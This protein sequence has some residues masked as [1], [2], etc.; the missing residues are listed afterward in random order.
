MQ[1][2]KLG[3]MVAALCGFLFLAA[4][5]IQT[6]ATPGSDPVLNLLGPLFSGNWLDTVI[7]LACLVAII[8]A[9]V[10]NGP[11]GVSSGQLLQ[12]VA[13]GSAVVVS[14]CIA[15]TIWFATGSTPELVGMIAVT[16]LLQ[17]SIGFAA[18]TLLFF[19][20]ESRPRATVPLVA[21]TG[22]FALVIFLSWGSSFQ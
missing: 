6:F 2:W 5:G 3:L 21:N 17:G 16:A 22:L 7:A 1:D 8:V 15:L 4:G 10:P 19:R 11:G 20:S 14:V 18:A 9:L 13:L 12:G